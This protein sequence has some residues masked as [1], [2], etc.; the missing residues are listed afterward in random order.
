MK[1]LVFYKMSEETPPFRTYLVFSKAS[2]AGRLFFGVIHILETNNWIIEPYD[3]VLD[4]DIPVS[5][6]DKQNIYWANPLDLK[7]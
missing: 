5:E 3:L 2:E 1:T 4:G 7:D 6:E